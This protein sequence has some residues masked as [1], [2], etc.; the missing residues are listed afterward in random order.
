MCHPAIIGAAVLAGA[1]QAAS[2][3]AAN[4]SAKRINHTLQDQNA[5]RKREI[6][7]AAT[8]DIN[9]RL[10]EMRR[11]QARIE[12]AAGGAGLSLSSGSIEALLLDSA[13]QAELANDTSLANRE[14]RKLASDAETASRL[15]SK[16]TLLGAGLKIGLAAGGA[17]LSALPAPEP[18]PPRKR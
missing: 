3:I 18:K 1:S 13:M 9:E 16:T 12:V 2:T 15:Q 11:E 14:S 5:L 8:H 7:Q 10:R 4:Q 6:D 17:A